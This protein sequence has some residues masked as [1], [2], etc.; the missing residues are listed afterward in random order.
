MVEND[1]EA[2]GR[3]MAAEWTIVGPDDYVF[4]RERFLELIA[5]GDLVHTVMESHDVDVRVYGDAAVEIARG[6]SGGAHR[7]TPFY[8]VERVTCVWVR[9]AGAWVCVHTHLSP[10]TGT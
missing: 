3:Y 7:G 2:I 5:S 4:G 1:P 6:V 8:L 9:R 10:I